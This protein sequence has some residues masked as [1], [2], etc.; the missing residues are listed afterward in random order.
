M[1]QRDGELFVMARDRM[2]RLHDLNQDGTYDYQKNFHTHS[3]TA[4]GYHAFH[5]DLVTD[6]EAPSI[7]DAP[8]GKP[9]QKITIMMVFSK[10]VQMVPRSRV[11]VTGCG[12]PTGSALVRRDR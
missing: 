2:Y 5:F 9:T 6:S 4:P 3:D 10:L 11:C 1:A 8:G 12:T 7:M